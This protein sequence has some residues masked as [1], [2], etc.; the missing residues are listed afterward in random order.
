[1]L[2]IQDGLYTT[3]ELNVHVHVNEIYLRHVF[4]F[5]KLLQQPMGKPAFI[6]F[7]YTDTRQAKDLSSMLTML[8][9]GGGGALTLY[10]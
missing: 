6:R 2:H 10:L 5:T 4:R 9:F 3:R 8:F 1:M 7:T